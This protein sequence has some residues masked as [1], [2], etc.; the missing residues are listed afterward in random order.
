V[1]ALEKFFGKKAGL[2]ATTIPRLRKQW[3]GKRERFMRGVR[4][5]VAKAVAKIEEE[6]EALLTFY[7]FPAE[8]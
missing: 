8:H 7:E 2:S 3:Q 4:R 5:E 1:L 6:K